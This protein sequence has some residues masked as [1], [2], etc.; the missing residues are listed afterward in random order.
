MIAECRTRWLSGQPEVWIG[1]RTRQL[2]GPPWGQA[3]GRAG[4][5]TRKAGWAGQGSAGKAGQVARWPGGQVG[6]RAASVAEDI[7][8]TGECPRVCPA[9]ALIRAPPLV[10]LLACRRHQAFCACT[11]PMQADRRARLRRVSC[12][13]KQTSAQTRV[14][15]FNAELDRVLS[16]HVWTG[17]GVRLEGGVAQVP[18]QGVERLVLTR[19]GCLAAP[20]DRART[21]SRLV[22]QAV[23]GL[24]AAERGHGAK[25][26]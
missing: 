16:S 8:Q 1:D 25:T 11:D 2:D 20:G 9:L 23:L 24:R 3:C 10:F 17:S 5:Q 26:K 15:R 4:R 13:R 18:L 19:F 6:R 22:T 7:N 12:R 21:S 14:W